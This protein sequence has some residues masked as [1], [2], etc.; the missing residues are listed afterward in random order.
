MRETIHEDEIVRQTETPEEHEISRR[1]FY[2]ADALN[3]TNKS[4]EAEKKYREGMDATGDWGVY[5]H[6]AQGQIYI[7]RDNLEYAL[8]EFE[9]ASTINDQIDS[10][11]ISGSHLSKT[12][13]SLT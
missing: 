4:A 2:E 6:L 13:W 12:C 8:T 11:H 1:L 7:L 10:V 3:Y 9:V 5:Y